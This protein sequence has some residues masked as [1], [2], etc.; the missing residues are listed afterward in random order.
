M[1]MTRKSLSKPSVRP[2]VLPI[3]PG[4]N[5]FVDVLFDLCFV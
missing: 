2:N 4:I 5:H 1:H 3:D